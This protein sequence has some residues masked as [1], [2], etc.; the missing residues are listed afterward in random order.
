MKIYSNDEWAYVP[1]LRGVLR[2]LTLMHLV[3]CIVNLVAYLVLDFPL[4][5]W[6]ET[7]GCGG[8]QFLTRS[9][10]DESLLSST[11]A[12]TY[13]H[14]VRASDS[15]QGQGHLQPPSS[16]D[17]DSGVSHHDKA[18]LL[19]LQMAQPPHS[20]QSLHATAGFSLRRYWRLLM[21]CSLGM[22]QGLLVTLSLLGVVSSPFFSVACTV[23]Y[24][25]VSY[26]RMVSTAVAVGAPKLI[27]S[28]T[29]GL[30]FL[31]AC[32]FFSY[33]F[34]SQ[35]AIY[36]DQSCHSP[37]QCVFKHVLDAFRGDM[38]TV[39]GQFAAWTFPPM[40]VWEDMWHESRTLYLLVG[41]VFWNMVLQP[42]MQGQIIDAFAEIRARHS[43]AEAHLA[44]K[45]VITGLERQRFS[46]CPAEWVQRKD[47]AYALRYL[48]F[49]SSLL[50]RDGSDYDGLENS[51]LHVLLR[52]SFSFFP[53]GAFSLDT[54]QIRHQ[55]HTAE[56]SDMLGTLLSD[57]SELRVEVSD[58]RQMLQ[59]HASAVQLL[60]ARLDASASTP[61]A[62]TPDLVLPP[63]A[64]TD[65][66]ANTHSR[67]FSVASGLHLIG[68][69]S[70]DVSTRASWPLSPTHF[71]MRSS[72]FL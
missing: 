58:V 48:L 12:H 68:L 46:K 5:L 3:S 17:L 10:G 63:R 36:E 28:F 27:R 21:A 53:I 1:A 24:L 33:T 23:D 67:S 66:A 9:L 15:A 2:M 50:E 70:A 39:L 6:K 34:Y 55:S 61:Q 69:S 25:R 38:T 44:S 42:V 8:Y 29:V 71:P 13:G 35:I 7:E 43:A 20:A 52:C 11:G 4:V 45:C 56:Q 26:G 60:M 72:S 59:Q 47:G 18:K 19:L 41:L 31:V 65:N 40:V 49:F 32:G 57:F 16:H 22:Y 54:A 37:F 14:G 51:V 62:M 30:L 64:V